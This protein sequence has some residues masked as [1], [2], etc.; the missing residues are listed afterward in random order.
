M[1]LQWIEKPHKFRLG[2]VALREIKKYQKSTE[3][4]IESYKD[5]LVRD[6]AH[7]L[8]SHQN[9]DFRVLLFWHFRKQLNNF[10][11]DYLKVSFMQEQQLLCKEASNQLQ[12]QEKKI[13]INTF[14][15][16]KFFYQINILNYQL[17]QMSGLI[18]VQKSILKNNIYTIDVS[19]IL[20]QDLSMLIILVFHLLKN[21]F[22]LGLLTQI[23]QNSL[24]LQIMRSF[25]D[26][27]HEV[28]FEKNK[29]ET[30]QNI[31]FVFEQKIAQGLIVFVISS[32]LYFLFKN[33]LN[34]IQLAILG[35]IT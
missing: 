20:L 5:Q 2:T 26:S 12:D 1:V 9:L 15:N 27:K 34:P 29:K 17:T 22:K 31:L 3:L 13:L 32:S 6:I 8:I 18:E 30:L 23:S 35:T 19:I 11:Q 10:Q 4:L 21:K 16:M 7:D 14:I 33:N 28:I 24:L 25:K